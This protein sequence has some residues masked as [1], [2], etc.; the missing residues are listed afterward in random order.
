MKDMLVLNKSILGL[1]ERERER[2]RVQNGMT[3]VNY[4]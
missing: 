1:G 3:D 4:R 2:E